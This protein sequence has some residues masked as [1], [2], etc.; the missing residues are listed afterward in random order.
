MNCCDDYCHPCSAL[1][2]HCHDICRPLDV[3]DFVADVVV[4]V[5]LAWE[6]VIRMDS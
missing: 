1:A 2:H 3:D 5:V 6:V 4:V